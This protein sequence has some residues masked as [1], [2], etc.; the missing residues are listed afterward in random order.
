LLY[1]TIIFIFSILVICAILRWNHVTSSPVH[2]LYR[3]N[4]M[5]VF[6]SAEIGIMVNKSKLS[7]RCVTR[8]V[9]FIQ[10]VRLYAECRYPLTNVFSKP[11]VDVLSRYMPCIADVCCAWL[12]FDQN[13]YISLQLFRPNCWGHCCS[14]CRTAEFD[15]VAT[16]LCRSDLGS[17]DGSLLLPHWW[18]PCPEIFITPLPRLMYIENGLCD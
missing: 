2:L 4:T 17:D 5:I 9:C 13:W 12:F 10:T 14:R 8:I 11:M 16:L 6:Y 18:N 15:R 7:K 1:Y 3:C